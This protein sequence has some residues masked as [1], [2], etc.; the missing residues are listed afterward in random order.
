[1]LAAFLFV[2]ADEIRSLWGNPT[3]IV[4]VESMVVMVVDQA[5]DEL[6]QS[7]VQ[8]KACSAPTHLNALRLPDGRYWQI[9]T[10][11]P[12]HRGMLTDRDLRGHR[13]AVAGRLFSPIQT[14]EIQTMQDLGETLETAALHRH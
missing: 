2:N 6:G 12:A 14:F 1:M 10:Q 4:P 8:Q 11:V 5:C 7:I 9:S 13:L 3:Q